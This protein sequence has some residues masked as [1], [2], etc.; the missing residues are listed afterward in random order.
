ME[1]DECMR[2]I[3]EVVASLGFLTPIGQCD[4]PAAPEGAMVVAVGYTGASTGRVLIAADAGLGGELARNMLGLDHPASAEDADEAVRELANV[5]AGNLVPLL[6]GEG[7]VALDPPES[8]DLAAFP[9]DALV[10]E[11]LEGRLAVAF[12]RAAAA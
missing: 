8:A 9:G 7:E 6:V 4:P 2:V 10:L 11:L 12:A 3:A 1:R 5:L